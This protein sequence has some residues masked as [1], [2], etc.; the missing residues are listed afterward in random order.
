M[1][2]S[3]SK[4]VQVGRL[5]KRSDFLRLQKSGQMWVSKSLILQAMEQPEGQQHEPF[6]FG[7]TVTRRTV[8]SAV[9]RNRIKRRLR[10]LAYDTLP[11]MAK[12]NTDFVLIGRADTAS[13]P[14]SDL[15][16]D[17]KWC[18]KRLSCLQEDENE[19]R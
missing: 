11:D 6:R 16:R 19:D 4:M 7:I 8:K 14:Y 3:R 1:H 5:K 12:R 13:F 15:E 9:G 10:A 2:A 17:L 18:L